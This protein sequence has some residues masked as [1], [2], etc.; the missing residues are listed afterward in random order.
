MKVACPKCGE[1]IASNDVNVATDAAWCARCN[2]VFALS[3]L[4]G[5]GREEAE[6][7]PHDVPSEP[8]RGA[9]FRKDADGW[10]L[11]ATTRGA[12]AFFLVPFMGVWSGV[13]L[14]GIYGTQIANGQFNLVLSLF[15]LPFLA[16]TVFLGSMAVMT[17]CGKV[18]VRVRQGLGQGL[19][20]VF[21]GAGVIGWRKRFD[22]KAIRR[23]LE[24]DTSGTRSASTS[25]VLEGEERIVFGSPLSEARR[26][27]MVQVLRAIFA[28]ERG[29][30]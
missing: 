19:G 3:S 18:R 27:F 13:S 30:Q 17:I 24:K 28:R 22:P 26:Y 10:E 8:P 12:A 5:K 29:R 11:G 21:V 16:G 14:G 15:G 23:V 25:I 9:W 1:E 6:D 7:A 4:L 20:Q 2:E